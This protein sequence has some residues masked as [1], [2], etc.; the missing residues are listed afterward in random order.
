MCAGR[1]LGFGRSARRGSG[2][3]PVADPEVCV[4]VRPAGRCLC[5]LVSHLA[6]EHV[7]GAVTMLHLSTP[8][9]PVDVGAAHDTI[10]AQRQDQQDLELPPRETH[11]TAVREGLDLIGADLEISEHQRRLSRLA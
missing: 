9:P 11:A 5:E 10:L 6:Y 1:Q 4:D 2:G 3:E 7:H 8:Y